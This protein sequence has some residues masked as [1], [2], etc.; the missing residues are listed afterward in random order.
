MRDEP[1][2]FAEMAG[3]YCVSEATLLLRWAVQKGMVVL[4]K[5][6]KPERVAQ[7]FDLFS[8]GDIGEEDMAALSAMDKGQPLAWPNGDPLL[9]P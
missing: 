8:F 7:N 2:V 6:S 3:R 1:S 9:T 4:P 5:S